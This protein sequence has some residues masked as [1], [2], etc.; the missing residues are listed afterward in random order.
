V[1][2]LLK[3][4][5]G[6]KCVRREEGGGGGGIEGEQAPP[7]FRGDTKHIARLK[8]DTINFL[9]KKILWQCIKIKIVNR[10]SIQISSGKQIVKKV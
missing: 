2:R 5:G 4:S 10:D 3:T 6:K 7:S 8:L 9:E 1:S